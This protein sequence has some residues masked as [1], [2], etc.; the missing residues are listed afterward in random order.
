MLY[1]KVD[2]CHLNRNAEGLTKYDHFEKVCYF[3]RWVIVIILPSE[4]QC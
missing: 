4:V 1:V 2:S 3:N